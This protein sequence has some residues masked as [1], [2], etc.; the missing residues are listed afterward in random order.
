MLQVITSNFQK[1]NK[2]NTN[3]LLLFQDDTVNREQYNY[4]KDILD[5]FK[6]SLSA[7]YSLNSQIRYDRCSGHLVIELIITISNHLMPKDLE[8]DIFTKDIIEKFKKFY[9]SQLSN[10]VK[11]KH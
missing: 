2:D 6:S 5:N 3:V 8:R 9:E 10:F 4:L 11:N 1:I 7:E